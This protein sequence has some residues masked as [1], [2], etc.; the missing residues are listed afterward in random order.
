MAVTSKI[1]WEPWE[2][3]VPPPQ[4]HVY[5]QEIAGPNSLPKTNITPEN[6]PSQEETSIPTIHF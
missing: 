4:G 2:P 1:P 5:P 6:R 3:K